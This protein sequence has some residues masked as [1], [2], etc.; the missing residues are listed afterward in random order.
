MSKRSTLYTPESMAS[1]TSSAKCLYDER[2]SLPSL[3]QACLR[4]C[5]F[6]CLSPVRPNAKCS[7]TKYLRYASCIKAAKET[8]VSMSSS[9][10]TFL[11]SFG[12]HTFC[13]IMDLPYDVAAATVIMAGNVTGTL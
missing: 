12:E 10:E 1:C 9:L 13:T 3:V 11:C 2:A 6:W 7:L 8:L 4:R 5:T